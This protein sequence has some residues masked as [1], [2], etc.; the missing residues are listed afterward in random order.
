MIA[1]VIAALGVPVI[2]AATLSVAYQVLASTFN[3]LRFRRPGE[4]VDAGGHRLYL[5]CEGQEH[6]PVLIEAGNGSSSLEWNLVQPRAAAV[7]RVCAYDR[8]G[9][10]WSYPAPEGRTIVERA[11]ELHRLIGSRLSRPLI[12]IGHSYGGLIVRTYHKKY[13]SEVAGMVWSTLSRVYLRYSG[14]KVHS[15]AASAVTLSALFGESRTDST[16]APATS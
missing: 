16:L 13:T 9:L 10:G 4:M 2:L 5:R 8:A 6:P 11:E 12:L 3:K 14:L 15:R 7:T 1:R